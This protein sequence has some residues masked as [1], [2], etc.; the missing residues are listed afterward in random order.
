MRRHS[1]LSSLAYAAILD[2]GP[3]SSLCFM[4]ANILVVRG[5]DVG[6]FAAAAAT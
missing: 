2:I 4:L 1:L 3:Q 5:C 6:V